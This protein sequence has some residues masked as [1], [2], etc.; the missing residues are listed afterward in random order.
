VKNLDKLVYWMQVR[1]NI[2]D[3]KALGKP[4]PWSDDK[5]FQMT[6]FCNVRREDDK[7][8]KFIRQM[9]S[10]YVNHP[11]FVHNIILSRFLNW[12]DTLGQIGYLDDWNPGLVKV[13]CNM[14]KRN[15]WKV[16]GNAYVVTTHGIKMDKI[17]YLCDRVMPSVGQW[18]GIDTQSCYTAARDLQRIEGISTF[19]AGQ[20]V[21]DL[22]N[23]PGHPLTHAP[24]WFSFALPGP[25]SVRG[26]DWLYG[27][28][29]PSSKWK[30]HLTTLQS[31]LSDMGWP[32]C[33]QDIQN[34]LCEFD[35]YM[36]VSTGSGR[37]KRG[38]PG[39]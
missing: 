19:M 6:Y 34:C 18:S 23:T 32:L 30:D 20:V 11:L 3:K 9:Y 36:R 7:V 24:D 35:K 2:A 1:Q 25:G 21:A 29:V 8:T 37:S 26:M 13:Q 15:G 5:V 17:D 16:W 4:K 38:Y 27:E 31:I 12:P 39:A 10:P 33:Q 28:K 22:K 14:A